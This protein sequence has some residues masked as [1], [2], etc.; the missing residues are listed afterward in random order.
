[1]GEGTPMVAI[2]LATGARRHAERLIVLEPDR[3]PRE[4]SAETVFRTLADQGNVE[5]HE[6]LAFLAAARALGLTE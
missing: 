3:S 4:P 6:A 5:A 2:D 1:M